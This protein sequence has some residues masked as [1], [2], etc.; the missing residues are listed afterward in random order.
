MPTNGELVDT[1]K[2]GTAGQL[3]FFIRGILP[4]GM[5]C[6]WCV[7][8]V[9]NPLRGAPRNTSSPPPGISASPCRDLQMV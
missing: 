2:I 8:Q 7:P 1:M 6:R 5:G 3:L 4:L 9:R